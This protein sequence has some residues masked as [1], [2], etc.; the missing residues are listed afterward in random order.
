MIR[1]RILLLF[2]IIGVFIVGLWFL[3]SGADILNSRQL[4]RLKFQEPCSRYTEETGYQVRY[5]IIMENYVD[6][7]RMAA[8]WGLFYNKDLVD[9][10][11]MI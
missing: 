2:L 7:S 5:N 4:S 9:F 8:I 6:I 10:Y 1:H 11:S 3:Y